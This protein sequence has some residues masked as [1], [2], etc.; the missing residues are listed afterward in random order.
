M[1]LI[2]GNGRIILGGGGQVVIKHID[3]LLKQASR[4]TIDVT[5]KQAIIDALLD[6]RRKQAA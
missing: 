6:L 5:R 2:A 3:I 4:L 1:A